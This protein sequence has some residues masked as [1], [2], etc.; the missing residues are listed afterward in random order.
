MKP[1]KGQTC[2]YCGRPDCWSELKNAAFYAFLCGVGAVA[3]IG[4]LMG[5]M[6]LLDKAVGIFR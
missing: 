3:W 5:A 4:G 1:E 6:W 2:P